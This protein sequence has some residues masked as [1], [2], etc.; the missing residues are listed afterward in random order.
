MQRGSVVAI[1]AL[2]GMLA[3]GWH[4]ASRDERS[5]T[6]EVDLD[7]AEAPQRENTS[8]D[9]PPAV[10][11][12]TSG[13]AVVESAPLPPEGTPLATNLDD[14]AVRAR[15]G[16]N[17]AAMRLVTDL[18]RCRNRKSAEHSIASNLA[19]LKENVS[20]DKVAEF[21]EIAIELEQQAEN[22][23]E[24]CDGANEQHLVTRGEWLVLAA[25]R[26]DAEAMACFAAH[27]DSFAPPFLSDAWFD[28]AQKWRDQALPFALAAYAKGE[29]EV[30]PLLADA[31]SGGLAKGISFANPTFAELVE[32]DW[33]R[34]AAYA[35]LARL[36]GFLPDTMAQQFLDRLDMAEREKVAAHVARDRSR[37]DAA[38]NGPS[39]CGRVA[40]G[41]P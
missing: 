16:D 37:F 18:Q 26:G 24:L 15:A 20:N 4:F 10:R 28:W 31:Y 13:S 2:V 34:A 41:M 40:R 7:V 12:P 29:S 9:R 23:R 19:A 30:L 35:E 32:V 3:I 39:R 14:L 8:I 27:P 21:A 11:P 1:G 36:K 33:V 38:S 22:I 25:D 17:A 5:A 6:R